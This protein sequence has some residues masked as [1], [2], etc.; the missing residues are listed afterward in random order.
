M[1]TSPRPAAPKPASGQPHTPAPEQTDDE[2][3]LA[4]M[5]RALGASGDSLGDLHAPKPKQRR[6][7]KE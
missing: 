3:E 6:S 5:M 1:R 4:A 7:T 2:A